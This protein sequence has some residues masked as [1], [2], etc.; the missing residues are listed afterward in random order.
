[1]RIPNVNELISSAAEIRP[2]TSRRNAGGLPVG[3]ESGERRRSVFEGAE[4]STVTLMT[5]HAAKG[6][7]FPV[8]SMIGLEE[9]C[10]PHARA[11]EDATQLE[12]E[13]AAVFRGD[14]A[15][16]RTDW[17]LSTAAWQNPCGGCGRRRSAARFLSEMPQEFM[18][19]SQAARRAE[20]DEYSQDEDRGRW[21]PRGRPRGGPPARPWARRYYRTWPT[22][23]GPGGL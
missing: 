18:E 13:Q 7:E 4:R 6:L 5:L 17:I 22:G 3:G 9:G 8:V 11:Q 21:Q 12:E 14:H 16:A 19:V 23:G 20:A 2:G 10:L 1:M 15:G